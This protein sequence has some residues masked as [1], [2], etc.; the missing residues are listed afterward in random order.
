MSELTPIHSLPDWYEQWRERIYHWISDK[1]RPVVADTALMVP[2]LL[3]LLVRL[4]LDPRTPLFFKAQLILVAVYTLVPFDFVPE[5]I[6]GAAGL[7]DDAVIL[8]VMLLKVVQHA[9]ALDQTVLQESWSG[10][11]DIIATLQLIATNDQK[12]I[13]P[14]LWQLFRTVLG[15]QP[16]LPPTD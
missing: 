15:L 7:A 16:E 2:D 14:R 5:A 4:M 6:L 10:R 8:S 3:A 13:H 9:S 11:G 12:L 1:T